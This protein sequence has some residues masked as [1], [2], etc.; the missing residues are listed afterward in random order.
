MSRKT[1]A[2]LVVD[3]QEK[4]VPHIAKSATVIW[5]IRRLIDGAHVL[6]VSV[7]A[8]EQ[9]PK[10]LGSTVPL[11]A[12]RITI[13]DEKSMFSCRDCKNLVKKLRDEERHQVLI[14]GI[15][16]HVC[17]LQTALDLISMGFEVWVAVDAIGSRYSLDHETAI[18]RLEMAGANLTTTESALFEW[19]EVSG[20]HEFKRISSLVRELAP[21]NADTPDARHFPRLSARY[22][23]EADHNEEMAGGETTVTLN[24]RVRSTDTGL[25]AH[26]F[27]GSF[28]RNAAGEVT[29][30]E[31]VQAVEVS[32]DGTSISSQ[33]ADDSI[34]MNYLP[35][36]DA[37]TN[38]PR[39]KVRRVERHINSAEYKTDYEIT[40]SVVDYLTDET[41][42]EYIGYEHREAETGKLTHVSGVRQVEIASDGC[43]MVVTEFGRAPEL[44][45]LAK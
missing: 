9:Y 20:T 12:E 45:A 42:R 40:F 17:V 14:S 21:Q 18:R 37:R 24:Y 13:D 16:S 23:I 10:G 43:W 1:S 38:H 30:R 6:G 36:G 7:R 3:V 25:A 31:G 34:T 5:N 39:W 22:V 27:S 35:I 28:V 29:R 4:L 2:L 32:A 33:S 26:E 8:A 44:T 15:E 11:L 41:F 19:C